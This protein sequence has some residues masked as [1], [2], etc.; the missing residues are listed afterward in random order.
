MVKKLLENWKN[1]SAA[2]RVKHVILYLIGVGFMPLGV[3]LTV[4]AHLGAGGYDAL[5]FALADFFGINPSLAIFSTAFCVLL[6]TAAIRRGFPNVLTFVSSFFLGLFTDFWEWA[7]GRV[8]AHSIVSGVVL[9]VL[10]LAVIGFAV[11]CYVISI[12]PTNPTD[13]LIVALH[14]KG[15]NLGLSK[16]L[17][18]TICAAIAFLLGGEIGLGTVLVTFGLGPVIDLNHKLVMKLM[19]GGR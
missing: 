12:F 7:L 14:E 6:I 10:G 18:D 13:D 16:I 3:V 19:A 9:M 17:L 11:A 15:W 4:N 8:E 1:L 5:N 2:D